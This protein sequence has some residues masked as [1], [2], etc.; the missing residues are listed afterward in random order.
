MKAYH[1]LDTESAREEYLVL[2]ELQP[3]DL[4]QE[5]LRGMALRN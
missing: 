4:Q 3:L 1:I 5:A 2:R